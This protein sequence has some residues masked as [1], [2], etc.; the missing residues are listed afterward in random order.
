MVNE[1]RTLRPEVYATMLVAQLAGDAEDLFSLEPGGVVLLLFAMVPETL[2]RT[3]T[4]QG[5][6]RVGSNATSNKLPHKM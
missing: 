6:P 1:G 3:R 5:P 4:L 2:D